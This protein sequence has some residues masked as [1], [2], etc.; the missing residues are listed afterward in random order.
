M[1]LNGIKMFFNRIKTITMLGNLFKNKIQRF[2]SV[3]NLVQ[4]SVGEQDK[5]HEFSL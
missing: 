1:V 4:K 2:Y 3:E 5:T